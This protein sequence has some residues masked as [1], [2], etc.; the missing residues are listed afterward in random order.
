MDLVGPL[1]IRPPQAVQ[2]LQTDASVG[3][4]SGIVIQ[5]ILTPELI[6]RPG[7]LILTKIHQDS[8]TRFEARCLPRLNGLSRRSTAE[9]R[10]P[11]RTLLMSL[12]HCLRGRLLFFA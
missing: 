4:Q 2:T 8:K 6:E 7:T 12:P 1:V 9:I 10:S 11:E 5:M 3:R